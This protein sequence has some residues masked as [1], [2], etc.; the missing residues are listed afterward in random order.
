MLRKI[1]LITPYLSF[2]SEAPRLVEAFAFT[3]LRKILGF[4]T[5][6]T[7]LGVF[8]MK[9][10]LNAPNLCAL[11]VLPLDSSQAR[12]LAS[13]SI[14]SFGVSSLRA[15]DTKLEMCRER[16]AKLTV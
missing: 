10:E 1:Q 2:A 4:L 15:E 14:L 6:L 13:M 3:E 9:G 16:A 8:P 7:E 5:E 12:S 11:F